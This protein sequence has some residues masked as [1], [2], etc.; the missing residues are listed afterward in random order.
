MLLHLIFTCLR[1]EVEHLFMHLQD[2][3]IPFPES[4]FKDLP[5]FLLGC[6]SFSCWFVGTLCMLKSSS[7]SSVLEISPPYYHLPFDFIFFMCG[8][9]VFFWFW[10]KKVIL[11]LTLVSFFICRLGSFDILIILLNFLIHEQ[12]V[13]FCSFKSSF[14]FFIDILK[15]FKNRSFTFFKKC[16]SGYILL[17]GFFCYHVRLDTFWCRLRKPRIVA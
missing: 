7:C 11:A 16:I 5:I 17:C 10:K 4:L 15:V 8:F 14:R 13:S 2:I 1:S 12:D 6:C 3:C 9:M